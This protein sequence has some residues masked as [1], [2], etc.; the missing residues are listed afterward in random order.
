MLAHQALVREMQAA[1][2]ILAADP[3][4]TDVA[5]YLDAQ[6]EVVTRDPL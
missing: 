5:V 6:R 4:E 1:Y 3:E 2:E